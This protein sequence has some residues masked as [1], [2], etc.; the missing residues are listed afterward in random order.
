MA[1]ML[2]W[3]PPWTMIIFINPESDSSYRFMSSPTRAFLPAATQ[4]L[5]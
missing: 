4:W 1:L 5:P 2:T 3:T